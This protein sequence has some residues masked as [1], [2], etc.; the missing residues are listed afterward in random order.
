MVG[1]GAG[2]GDDLHG[3]LKLDAALAQQTDLLR[4]DHA[5][6]GVVDLDGGVVGQ[7]VVIAAPGGALCQT[8]LGT[9]RNQDVYKRQL[10]NGL[11]LL[12]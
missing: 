7:I 6:M 3:L 10:L 4:D 11:L 8:E 1:V 9:G 2:L 12:C 5:G